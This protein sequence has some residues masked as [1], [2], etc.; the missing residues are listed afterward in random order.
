VFNHGRAEYFLRFSVHSSVSAPVAAAA[1]T[2]AVR[3]PPIANYA[4]LD[5]SDVVQ[6]LAY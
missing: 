1:R 2:K 4:C 5:Q 3:E 6:Q